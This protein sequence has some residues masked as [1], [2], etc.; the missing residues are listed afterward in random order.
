MARFTEILRTTEQ[1]TRQFIREGIHRVRA[2][3]FQSV[4]IVAASMGAWLFSERVLGHHEPIFA[5]VAA[6]VSLGY[7][8]GAKHSR[9]ILEVSFGVTL[10]ILIGDLL[11]ILLGHGTWQAAVVLFL[12]V[13]IA[14][15]IDKGIIFTI[16]LSFQACFTLLLPV[17]DDAFTRSFDGL[18]G[19]A[20]AFLAM[21]LMPRDPRKNPRERATALMDAFAKVFTLSSEAIRYY[22]YN[23]A[24]Q[25]LLD[26]RALQP[27]YDAGRG[28]LITAQGMNELSWNSRKS[29]GELERMSKTLAAIDLAIRN[30]RVLNRRMAS[31]IHHVQLRSAAQVSLSEALNELSLASQSIGLGMSSPKKE[32]REYYMKKAQDRMVHLAGTLEPRY[33][34]VASFEG[35]SLVLMLRLIVVDF[36]EAT[37]MSHKDAL[38]K[39]MPLGEAMTEHAPSTSVLP[40]VDLHVS[41]EE[42]EARA[43]EMGAATVAGSVPEN[44]SESIHRQ[45]D[46][47][48]TR[49]LNIILQE[50]EEEN[51]TQPR[52]D[53][54]SQVRRD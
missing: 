14:R 11:L 35:E 49:S 24:Y 7:V 19:G 44:A 25:S 47:L 42:M 1:N 34:G 30:D 41:P 10:G 31:T 21:Y 22:D 48:H 26:A 12:T 4:Q 43:A 50:N 5:P 38:D 18:V 9:R 39:L 45:S 17:P 3:F 8:S 28:D 23:K 37:G 32:E 40:M 13:I 52:T 33:M 46:L 15:F 2:D 36:L 51:V 16:Q 27:L 54:P 6:L 53:R 20:F 29:K